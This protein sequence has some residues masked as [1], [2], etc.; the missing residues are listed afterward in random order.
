MGRGRA[1]AGAP[2]AP[3]MVRN[4]RREDIPSLY[5]PR[6]PLG[7][8]AR[9]GLLSIIGERQVPMSSIRL[10]TIAVLLWLC[11]AVL[12]C[13]QIGGGSIVGVIVDQSGAPVAGVKVRAHNQDTN[14]EQQAVTNETGFY[15]FPL[16]HAGRYRL[17]AEAPGF[18]KAAGAEFSLNA[19]TRPRIDLQLKVGAV[20]G[21]VNF[22]AGNIRRSVG[23]P[24]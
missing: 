5:R 12:V 2:A 14:A 9:R 11:L 13:G 15:E 21:A 20:S 1:A 24:A 22:V 8:R 10:T 6:I 7:T 18:E 16:L 19:G 17:E 4:C 3:S 23:L